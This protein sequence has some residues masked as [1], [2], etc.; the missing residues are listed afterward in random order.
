M[1]LLSRRHALTR[2]A[3]LVG[4]SSLSGCASGTLINPDLDADVRSIPVIRARTD[5][6]DRITVC[7][8]P[9]RAAGPRLEVEQVGRKTVVHNYGHG[10]SG[11]SLS[12]GSAKLAV[13]RAL[14][15]SSRNIGVIGCGAIGLTTAIVAQQAG[16]QVTIYAEALPP[17]VRSARASG[18]WTPSSRIAQKDAVTPEFA[19]R[20]ESMARHS[21]SCY[22]G[23]QGLP[24]NPVEWDTFYGMRSR[25]PSVPHADPIGFAKLDERIQDIEPQGNL[26]RID[27]TRF[28]YSEVHKKPNLIFNV[29]SYSDYLLRQFLERGGKIKILT[30]HHPSELTTLPEPVFINCTGYGARALWHD[31]SI[32]PIRGQIAWLIPQP[33]ALC[34]MSF[35]NVYVV[36]RRDGIV[37]QWMGHDMGFGYNNTDEMPDLVEANHSVSII[38]KLYRRIG[39]KI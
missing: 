13:E 6:V 18:S 16:A 27:D 24:G 10:G 35:E 14:P 9:F 7:L 30:L 20:W 3:S 4:L 12:W 37:V 22:Q 11:W 23:L 15:V 5:R 26:I 36:S 2:G 31:D 21:F 25:E 39:Y 34:S 38:N 32:V 8:R 28:P 29:T 33:E 19:A 1:L 17:F